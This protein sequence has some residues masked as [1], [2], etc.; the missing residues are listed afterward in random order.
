MVILLVIL[1]AILGQRRFQNRE[2]IR[3]EW[4]RR[5]DLNRG[6]RFA[7]LRERGWFLK[8]LGAIAKFR[9]IS[10][11]LPVAWDA[12]RL[13]WT[14]Q[15]HVQFN[16][17]H[18]ARATWKGFRKISLLNIPIKVF[19]ATDRIERHDLLQSAQRPVP[20]ADSAET[21]VPTLQP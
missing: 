20:D 15:V 9:H 5:P 2:N 13:G 3:K 16:L 21:L 11:L 6:W 18:P 14:S 12:R 7:V 8:W 17:D 1:D 19:P 10:V 4:R